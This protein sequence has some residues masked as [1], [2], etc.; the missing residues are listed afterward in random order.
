MA[1]VKL[2]KCV[3]IWP[4]SVARYISLVTST[5]DMKWQHV[6]MDQ[7]VSDAN[8][9]FVVFRPV[10]STIPAHHPGTPPLLNIFVFNTNPWP[11]NNDCLY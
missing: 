4:L 3:D 8:S 2:M 6:M 1:Y 11:C 9:H 10:H 7:C 5:G